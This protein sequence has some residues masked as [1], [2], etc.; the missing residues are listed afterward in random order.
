MVLS[1][2]KI[3]F[4]SEIFVTPLSLPCLDYPGQMSSSQPQLASTDGKGENRENSAVD[5]SKVCTV[6]L[7]CILC[8][9]RYGYNV[10]VTIISVDN[11]T[12]HTLIRVRITMWSSQD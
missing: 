2:V 11:G 7:Q 10:L 8:F 9:S 12:D 3:Q 5:F 1:A 4:C 6:A